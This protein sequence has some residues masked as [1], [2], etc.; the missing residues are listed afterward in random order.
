[1]VADRAMA[2]SRVALRDPCRLDRCNE[3]A[4]GLSTVLA[5]PDGGEVSLRLDD[6]TPHWLIA[7]RARAGKTSL[8]LSLLYGLCTRYSPD[9][10][11]VYLLDHSGN[12]SFVDFAPSDEDASRLPHARVVG[13]ASTID[14][15]I[16]VLRS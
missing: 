1:M 7:G 2:R 16:A 12:R 10:L 13:L 3:D 8:L 5:R 9:Q 4:S 15:S 14:E 11:S 6:R